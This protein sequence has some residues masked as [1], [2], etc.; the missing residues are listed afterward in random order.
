MDASRS[1]SIAVSFFLNM[2]K[3][4]KRNSATLRINFRIFFA[5]YWA[6][7][8]SYHSVKNKT[9]ELNAPLTQHPEHAF[10]SN[11]SNPA[12]ITNPVALIALA[13]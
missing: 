13:I 4:V 5:L 10:P 1:A 2:F 8:I 9:C 6:L 11:P 3:H 7:R 12:A